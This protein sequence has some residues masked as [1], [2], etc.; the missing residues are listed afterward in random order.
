MSYILNYSK[1]KSLFEE[2]T[3][4]TTDLTTQDQTANVDLQKVPADAEKI[5]T[6]IS[7][8]FYNPQGQ[9]K[10]NGQ[11]ST[12][13]S[14][15]SILTAVP[16]LSQAIIEKYGLKTM[17]DFYNKCGYVTGFSANVPTS[18]S[19]PIIGESV[20]LYDVRKGYDDA[21]LFSKPKAEFEKWIASV[22]LDR[23]KKGNSSILINDVTSSQQSIR[24]SIGVEKGRGVDPETETY[25]TWK[26][27]DGSNLNTYVT[28][29]KKG[30]SIALNSDNFGEG[31]EA[32]VKL[33]AA[34]F[35]LDEEL[36]V[37]NKIISINLPSMYYAGEKTDQYKDS[38]FTYLFSGEEKEVTKTIKPDETKITKTTIPGEVA[39]ISRTINSKFVSGKSEVTPEMQ[40][41]IDAIVNDVK[42]K[43]K[44][45][46][47]ANLNSITV[48]SSASNAWT[49]GKAV[50]TS[51]TNAGEK[52]KDFTDDLN[53][54]PAPGKEIAQISDLSLK[55]KKLSWMRGTAFADALM[56]ALK[57]DEALKKVTFPETATIE[58]RITDTG[59]QF[60]ETKTKDYPK[61]GQYVTV[62]IE[63]ASKQKDETKT[64]VITKPGLKGTYP[65]IPVTGYYIWLRPSPGV[66][67]VHPNSK[68]DFL[69]KIGITKKTDA[70][71]QNY[72]QQKGAGAVVNPPV[73]PTK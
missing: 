33:L 31:A 22:N 43:V 15:S 69:T 44:D 13:S 71:V 41:E 3:Q 29:N 21:L 39:P 68:F 35:K 57:S 11:K 66:A 50:P 40:K 61:N 16:E 30:K 45:K 26:G 38:Y 51:H 19:V 73:T 47:K 48:I 67:Y 8:I 59:G 63:G 6:A 49:N 9:L 52:N 14:I 60:D 46:D 42:E 2:T 20:I 23:W 27:K 37:K 54:D 32:I 12:A 64:D 56:T 1:W 4:S 34:E 24:I 65:A 70:M 58:W 17:F 36:D 25:K 53:S 10:D 5:K 18:K 7:S 28:L 72:A 55:N 62:K